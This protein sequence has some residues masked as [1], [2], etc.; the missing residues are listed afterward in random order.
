MEKEVTELTN[1]ERAEAGCGPVRPDDRLRDAARGHSEDM[2]EREYFSHTS[3][4]GETP[5]DR[6][7]EAGYDTPSAENIAQGFRDAESVVEA[8]MNSPGHRANIL[9]CDSKATGV[10]VELD[11]SGAPYWTQMFGY[12]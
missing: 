1:A 4:E 5:W 11:G 2:A 3:P 12:Q 8:W 9:N 10:G 6:A 7:A